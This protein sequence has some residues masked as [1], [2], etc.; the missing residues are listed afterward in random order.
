MNTPQKVREAKK[1][2]IEARIAARN[3]GPYFPGEYHHFHN[4]NW[5]EESWYGTP[6]GTYDRW[7][8]M[9]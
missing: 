3:A 4:Y 8:V 9:K 7:L 1:A 6:V 2:R 5:F